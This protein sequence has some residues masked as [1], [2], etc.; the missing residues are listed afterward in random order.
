LKTVRRKLVTVCN[1][2]GEGIGAEGIITFGPST[3]KK[4]DIVIGRP[5]ARSKNWSSKHCGTWNSNNE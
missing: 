4:G 5:E 3:E 1:S 2:A